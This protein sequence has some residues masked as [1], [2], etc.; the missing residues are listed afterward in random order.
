MA[1]SRALGLLVGA[2]AFLS[3]AGPTLAAGPVGAEFQVNTYT[4]GWEFYADVA[5][6][7]GGQVMSVWSRLGDG[8]SGGIFAQGFDSDGNPVLGEFQVNTYTYGFQGR[9]A[10]AA[11]AAARFVV[12]W[13]SSDAYADYEVRGQ[14]LDSSGAPI[15]TEFQVNTYTTGAQG[16]TGVDVASAANGD[17]VV[18]WASYQDGYGYGVFGQRFDGSGLRAGTEFQVNTYTLGN[19]GRAQLDVGLA[20]ARAAAGQFVV[21]WS[22][23]YYQDGDGYGVFAQRFDS[24]GDPEGT[25]F[26]VNTYTTGDQGGY[27]GPGIAA[28]GIGNFIVA[29]DSYGQDGE[30]SGIFARRLDANGL[31]GSEF[32]VNTYTK[33]S[34][35]YGPAVTADAAGDFTVVWTSSAQDGGP[36]GG[37]FGQE[38]LADGTFVGAEFQVNTYTVGLQW[39]PAAAADWRGCQQVVWVSGAGNTMATC[40]VDSDCP[41]YPLEACIAGICERIDQQDGEDSG[42]FAQRY[43]RA[44]AVNHYRCYSVSDLRQPQFRNVPGVG[45]TDQF[46][47]DVVTVKKAKFLCNPVDKNGEGIADPSLHLCCYGLAHAQSLNPRPIVDVAS[48]F[49]TSRLAAR[50]GKLLCAP[51]TK[52]VV[53]P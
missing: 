1:R 27:G 19:Q 18:I 9:P 35:G 31:V 38:L 48:Q 34:Q 42:I 40:S 11:D 17:F 36:G 41:K 24:A 25:E 6:A 14:R 8:S 39:Y 28:D 23:G 37:I 51:C 30:E 12:V 7:A 5:A 45:L 49:Q 46:I 2:F 15:G 53:G 50:V 22:G 29:W 10:V 4:A 21:V 20:V 47:S 43:C 44:P 32:Q 52:T 26:Q 16:Y 3:A 13:T 33:G